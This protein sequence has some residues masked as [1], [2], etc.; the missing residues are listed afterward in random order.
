MCS[1][2]SDDSSWDQSYLDTVA[3]TGSEDIRIIEHNHYRTR[4]V[5][6]ATYYLNKMPYKTLPG[7]NYIFHRFII[8]PDKD[9]KENVLNKLRSQKIL[10]KSVFEPNSFVLEQLSFMNKQ[11]NSLVISLWI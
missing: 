4:R 8:L 7:E 6:V 11:L 5:E 1:H 9:Q 10:A 2:K 3:A